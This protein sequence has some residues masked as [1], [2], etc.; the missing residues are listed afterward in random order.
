MFNHT[1]GLDPVETVAVR[2][3]SHLASCRSSGFADEPAIPASPFR[4]APVG[5]YDVVDDFT[6]IAA[7]LPTSSAAVRSLRLLDTALVE[8]RALLG[9]IRDALAAKG[10]E[11]FLVALV[12]DFER[13]YGQI[14]PSP[15]AA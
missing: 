1:Q 3:R 6:L 7:E 15:A 11:P 14:D 5:V 12:A 4:S 13:K 2:Y 8:S 10:A 9:W